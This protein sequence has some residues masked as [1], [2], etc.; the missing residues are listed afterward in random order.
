[1]LELSRRFDALKYAWIEIDGLFM[2][3]YVELNDEKVLETCTFS[4]SLTYFY[5]HLLVQRCVDGLAKD[6]K[7]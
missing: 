6:I 1:M 4:Q 7:V 5:E 2:Y 3:S